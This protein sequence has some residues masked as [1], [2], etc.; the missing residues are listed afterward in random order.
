MKD[1]TNT[2]VEVNKKD[3]FSFQFQRKVKPQNA[4]T[5]TQLHTSHTLV[6]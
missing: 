1:I 2:G 5:T 4:Q 3:Q 6:K